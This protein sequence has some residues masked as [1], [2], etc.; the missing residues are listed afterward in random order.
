MSA[1]KDTVFEIQ[2]AIIDGRLTF[3]EIAA[4]YGV[5]VADVTLIA[6]EIND[7]IEGERELDVYVADNDYFDDY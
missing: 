3:A 6:E 2:E 5:Y 7:M 1:I 4:K